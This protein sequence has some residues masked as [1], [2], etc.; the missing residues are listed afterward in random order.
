MTDIEIK[1]I[2]FLLTSSVYSDNAVMKNLGINEEELAKAYE[3][4][5]K[6]GY[7]ESYSE[8]E[9]R[10]PKTGCSSNCCSGEDCSS[11]NKCS[12][13]NTFDTSKVKVI[14]VKAILEF[15]TEI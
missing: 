9:A 13:D 10:N 7:L 6:N 12:M 14:T 2:K 11:C 5:E 8:Y 1:L 15:E 4:L 3:S